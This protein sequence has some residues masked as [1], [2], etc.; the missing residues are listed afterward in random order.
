M[1][2]TYPSGVDTLSVVCKGYR[3]GNLYA[4]K[5]HF[6]ERLKHV[7]E[8]EDDRNLDEGEDVLES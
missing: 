6:E 8:N 2:K 3:L 7:A 1:L 4:N 5:K